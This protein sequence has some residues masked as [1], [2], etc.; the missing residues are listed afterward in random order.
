MSKF[1]IVKEAPKKLSKDEFLVN[2]PDFVEEIRAAKNEPLA[3]SSRKLTTV[4]HLRSIL[5]VIGELYDKENFNAYANIPY[6][7]YEGIEYK[8]HKE[9]GEK[10]VK[11][12]VTNHA[13]ML[14]SK[15]VEN[16]VTN[17]P[18]DTKVVYFVGDP[19]Y[20]KVLIRQGLAQESTK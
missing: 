16:K 7:K 19:E 4:N 8:D 9:L 11:R 17:R 6:S 12:M 15:Y 2:E 5:G 10:V 18:V 20:A 1:K 13:P 14:L 3:K